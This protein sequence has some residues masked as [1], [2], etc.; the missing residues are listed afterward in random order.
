MDNASRLMT[1]RQRRVSASLPRPPLLDL[2]HAALFA[3]LDGTLAAIEPHPDH[4]GPEPERTDLLAALAHALDGRLAVVSGRSLEDLDRVLQGCVTCMG[5]VHGLVR[6]GADGRV[7][8]LEP[9][10][11]LAAA[12]AELRGF[13]LRRDGVWIEDKRHAAA[14]H[15]RAAPSLENE[16]RSFASDVAQ[17]HGLVLQPGRMVAELRSPGADKGAAVSA[18]M[19]EPPFAGSVP[20]F[21]GD[22]L[23]DEHGFE[24]AARL[25]GYGVLVGRMR[26]T[27]ASYRL[28]GVEAALGWLRQSLERPA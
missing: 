23:T 9:H 12:L 26:P 3:D 16:V 14:L 24:E 6:R 13:A 15:Y 7:Q 22:D 18:F 4:V 20:V 28:G 5:A 11:G 21:I 10:P 17:R 19:A 8:A 2:A 1:P 27:A 25:G